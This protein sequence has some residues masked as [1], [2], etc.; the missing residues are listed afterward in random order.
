MSRTT[1]VRDSWHPQ[2]KE[3]REIIL[4]EMHEILAS[5]HFCNSRRYPALLRYVVESTLAGN[6]ENLKE[7]TLGVEVFDRPA[8]YDTNSDTVVRYTAGEVRK[9]LALYYHELHHKP[10]VQIQL[11]A[12][13]YVPEF[14]PAGEEGHGLH[15]PAGLPDQHG[16]HEAGWKY[17]DPEHRDTTLLA[18]AE[19]D[20]GH[21]A[22]HT[23]AGWRQSKAVWWTAACVLVLVCSALGWK[24]RPAHATSAM[25]EFW[26]PVLRNQ[27]AVMVCSG[28]SVFSQTHLSGV[29]TAGK[30]IQYPFISIQSASAIARLSGLIERSGDSTQLQAAATTPLTELR[31]RPVILVG[32]YNNQWTM[33]LAESVPYHL[34]PE[35]DAAVVDQAGKM[36]LAR[37]T[38]LPYSAADDYAIVARFKDSTT[39]NWVVALAGLG[40]NGTEAAA[41]FA[42]SPHY[43]QELRDRVGPDMGKRNVVAVLKIPVIDGKTGAPSM[44]NATLW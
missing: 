15:G 33:R 10:A 30:D 28:G 44:L 8:D 25:D 37:D 24:Y 29:A 9:R 20:D 5:P 32:G 1:L 21:A 36:H 31:D 26:T 19:K 16:I 7:R 22:R 42:T 12:G 39:G 3:D 34:A 23:V 41:V 40:R 17:D 18:R 13:S 38:S 35:S 11:P 27:G 2:T 6:A 43:V 14:I 4:R